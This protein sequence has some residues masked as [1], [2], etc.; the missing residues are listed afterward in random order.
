[1]LISLKNFNLFLLIIFSLFL[2][3]CNFSSNTFGEDKRKKEITN[4]SINIQSLLK[5]LLIADSELT[6]RLI[7][8]DGKQVY[9]YKKLPGDEDLI[10]SDVEERILLGTDYFKTDREQIVILL[11]KINELGINNQLTNIESGALG[12]WTASKKEILLDFK[13]VKRGSRTFLDV[14]R[15]EAIH[16]AQSCY[17]GSK[18]SYPKRIGLPLEFSKDLEINLSHKLYKKNSEEVINL[19]REAFTYSKVKGAALKLLNKFCL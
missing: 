19:E 17:G 18:N 1:M 9:E 5:N 8:K 13:V 7:F 6:P 3:S 16:L 2:S 15:H 11:R 12:T 10:I 14:L 4:F